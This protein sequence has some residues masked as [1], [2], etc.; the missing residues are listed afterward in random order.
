[1]PDF[2]S[3]G[4]L[5]TGAAVV[6][7][8]AGVHLIRRFALKRA[9]LD[10]PND[11]SSHDAPTPR[12]GGAAIAIVFV[13]AVIIAATPSVPGIPS[14]W[15]GVALVAALVAVLG[16]LD[17]C[18]Q[19]GAA[20]RFSGH[21]TAAVAATWLLSAHRPDHPLFWISAIGIVWAINFYNFMDG[22]D[23][24]AGSEAVC[25]GIFGA[26]ISLRHGHEAAGVVS[27]LI[28]ASSLGFLFWNWPPAKI[29]MGDVGSG[30]LGF[31]FG[32]L[33]IASGWG[34]KGGFGTWL[35]LLAMFWVDATFTLFRRLFNGEKIW[36]AHRSHLYQRAVQA[37]YTHKQVTLFFIAGNIILGCVAFA[38]AEWV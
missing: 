22:I 16:W 34:F 9:I 33:A 6:A 31:V 1:M 7:S 36:E 3:G 38:V 10:I 37:G 12:G 14:T 15:A 35:I 8:T 5:I 11:R 13:A 26:L 27:A 20:K 21:V 24:L 32:C 25:V 29:F 2:A 18:Y 28:A 23:G 19:L 4:L 30:F 17:D